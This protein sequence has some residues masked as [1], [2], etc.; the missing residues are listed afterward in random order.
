MDV[1]NGGEQDDR[2]IYLYRS[3]EDQNSAIIQGDWKLI[4]YRSGKRELYNI[5]D[6][7]SEKNNLEEQLSERADQMLDQLLDWEKQSIPLE[8]LP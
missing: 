7:I 5:A 8:L 6:D 1:L 4:K 2:V 3:Y